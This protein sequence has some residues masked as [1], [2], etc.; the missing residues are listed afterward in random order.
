MAV[1]QLLVRAERPFRN[2]WSSSRLIVEAFLTLT[3]NFGGGRAGLGLGVMSPAS[4]I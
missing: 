2:R 3:L 1:R 4:T